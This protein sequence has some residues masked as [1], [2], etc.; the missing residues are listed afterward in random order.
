M[1]GISKGWEAALEA[2]PTLGAA[3]A[4]QLLACSCSGSPWTRSLPLTEERNQR[5]AWIP[6]QSVLFCSINVSPQLFYYR[7]PHTVR[8]LSTSLAAG[9]VPGAGLCS[10][11]RPPA[12]A[13]GLRGPHSSTT[14]SLC[15]TFH[16][17]ALWGSAE[18]RG[19]AGAQGICAMLFP[20]GLVSLQ[21]LGWGRKI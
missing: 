17:N 2:Q 1:A 12:R 8:A 13:A 9:A 6:S 10:Q 18:D 11:L 16:K 7:T 4:L 15:P 21:E 3:G 19:A 20:L 5:A 14:N